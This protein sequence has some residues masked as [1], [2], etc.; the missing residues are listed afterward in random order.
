MLRRKQ[1][2]YGRRPPLANRHRD[3]G[4]HVRLQL[5]GRAGRALEGM[6]SQSEGREGSE[7]PLVE[8]HIHRLSWGPRRFLSMRGQFA[9]QRP[10]LGPLTTSCLRPSFS[11]TS[12]RSGPAAALWMRNTFHPPCVSPLRTNRRQIV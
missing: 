3:N 4:Y 6:G 10:H 7:K 1:M 2:V 8:V 11:A 12:P 5:G 9:E